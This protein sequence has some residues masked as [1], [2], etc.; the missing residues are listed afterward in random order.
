[1]VRKSDR[2]LPRTNFPKGFSTGA[3]LMGHEIPGCLLV[4][5]FALHT[6]AFR[7]IFPAPKV[8]KKA[9]KGGGEEDGRTRTKSAG[10][11]ERE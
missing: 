5:L 1:M 10:N 6:S 9:P 2:D 4:K 7:Q 3:N 8:P 11:G